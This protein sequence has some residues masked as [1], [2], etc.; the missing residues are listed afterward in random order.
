MF[1]LDGWHPLIYRYE[2]PIQKEEYESAVDELVGKLIEVIMFCLGD[3]RT[4]PHDTRADIP[5]PGCGPVVPFET[6][7]C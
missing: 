1:Y 5:C 2:P 4:V 3:G 6:P 7:N